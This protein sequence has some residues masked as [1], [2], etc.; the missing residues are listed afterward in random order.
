MYKKKHLSLSVSIYAGFL[1]AFAIPILPATAQEKSNEI[2][3]VLVTGSRIRINPLDQTSPVTS[4]SEEDLKRS[5]ITSIADFLQRLPASGGALNTRFNS[6]GNF[7]FPPDGGGIGAGAAQIDLRYLGAKRVLVLVDGVRWV[8]GSS[9]S[10]VSSA[11]DLNTIPNSIIERVEVLEDGT[12]AI[13]GADAIAGVVNIITKKNYQGFGVETYAGQFEQ[14]DGTTQEVSLSWGT[15]SEKTNMF[16]SLNFNDQQEVL[17]A[18]R[19]IAQTPIPRVPNCGAGC[20]SGTPQGRFVLTDPNTGN[21][22]DLTINDGVGGVPSYDPTNPGGGN[23]DFHVFTNADRFNFAPF[24]LV[25]APVKRVGIFS[26]VVHSLTDNIKLNTKALYNNRS[27]K[28]QAA[29]EP[30]FIGPEAGNGNL[31]D[32]ISVDASNPYNPFGFTIDAA[33]NPYFIGRRPLEGGPRV[34]EQN[35]DTF[36]SSLGL[37]GNFNLNERSF[38]W[39]MTVAYSKNRATQIK[40]G[41]YNSAK[42]KVALGPL[43]EC[44]ATPGCVPFNIFGGQGADGQGTI[45]PEMLD[46]VSFI[47][48][49]VSEQQLY[50][51][52]A[53]LSGS[54]LDL[55]AGPLGFAV[56]Y[57]RRKQRG[58]FE[59]DAVVVAGESAGVQSTP[60][61]GEYDTDEYYGELRIPLLS[62]QFLADKLSLSLAARSVEYNTFGSQTSSKLGLN[63]R[64]HSDILL[65]YSVSEG[66]RAPG[67]GE[68]FGSDARFD[69]TLNDP[70]SNLNAVTD[71]SVIDNCIALGVPEDGSYEQFNPQISVTTGGNS[72]LK[73]ETSQGRVAGLV[74]APSWVDSVAGVENLGVEVNYFDIKVDDAIQA[75]DAEVQLNRCISTLDPV[76]CAGISRTANGVINGFSNQLTNIGSI[77][78]SGYDLR[79]DYTS[80]QTSVGSFAVNWSSS[81][82]D[83]YVVAT[84]T[85]SGFASVDRA[86]TE[87]GDPETAYPELKST[88]KVDWLIADWS[89]SFTSRFIDQVSESCVGLS[90]FPGLCSNPDLENDSE[91]KNTM[92][93]VIYQDFQVTWF[94]SQDS[95][96][97]SLSFGINN[98]FDQDP[99]ECYS[100]AL[101][102]F[103][104]TTYDVPGRFFYMRLAYR[105]Q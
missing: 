37:D 29:P 26:Q 80:P 71:Q 90:D 45:T 56:G 11:T 68:L 10:G 49:D 52:T 24:N 1:S 75:V 7:G 43:E 69:Q 74:Y 59:P 31:M 22:L 16:F 86:G 102:G 96:D 77:E 55:P 30:L 78:T 50:D 13:Y 38:F 5:G 42:L 104:A 92:D 46:W 79:I 73:P 35:V 32:T 44:N 34:F 19:S 36:Y 81:I 41:G 91:S 105:M 14:G 51:F 65:R 66:F 93:A 83:K 94:N 18:D 103:D 27:S 28:N 97:L 58:F 70:C 85:S 62:E 20:S 61:S 82:L 47:Q 4:I 54:L 12:S 15:T 9:A 17:A 40:N 88:L 67:I 23:D 60:T 76:S 89:L 39:D 98:L 6:S 87:L 72:E 101:N 95:N 8:N 53:N 33:T 84:P 21:A 63:W 3:E 48:K 57:E 100:C 25:M 64:P 2:E 99:P